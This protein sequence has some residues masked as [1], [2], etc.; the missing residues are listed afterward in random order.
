MQGLTSKTGSWQELHKYCEAIRLAVF[1]NEQGVPRS[2]EMDGH[3]ETYHHIVIFN[4]AHQSIA[5][6]RLANSGKF[7]RMAVLKNYREQGVGNEL[8]RLIGQQARRLKL[9]QLTCHA[10]LSAEGFYAKNGFIRIGNPMDEAGIAH[11]KMF[12]ALS[13][14]GDTLQ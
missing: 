1:V 10:Q 9:E 14:A 5:T 2:L 4:E 8:L 3:D 6:T 11:I 7:G 13:A 12:K